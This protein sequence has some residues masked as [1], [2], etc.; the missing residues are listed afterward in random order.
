MT[1]FICPLT[2]RKRL[3]SFS[4]ESP[5]PQRLSNL[6]TNS[7]LRFGKSGKNNNYQTQRLPG[8]LH[9]RPDWR[10]AVS[11]IAGGMRSV[12]AVSLEFEARKYFTSTVKLV[13]TD[14]CRE[15][16]TMELW[17]RSRVR[18]GRRR[19]RTDSGKY[20]DSSCRE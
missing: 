20:R 1:R 6:W 12:V 18:R 9:I 7:E 4:A 5:P 3:S 15:K 13:S 19:S 14:A 8:E 11:G 17:Q 2:L 10:L 16:L